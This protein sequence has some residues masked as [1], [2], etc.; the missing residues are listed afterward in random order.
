MYG[1]LTSDYLILSAE[2][3][4]PVIAQ[5]L[6]SPD[7]SRDERRDWA[8][9]MLR[10]EEV[11][12]ALATMTGVMSELTAAMVEAEGGGPEG[13]AKVNAT[14]GGAEYIAAQQR[15]AALHKELTNG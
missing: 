8:N 15:L 6:F 11:M 14:P 9:Y 5:V 3:G 13:Y 7:M 10:R 12:G 4:G 1:R 2:A